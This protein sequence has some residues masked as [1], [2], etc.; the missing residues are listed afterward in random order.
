MAIL[1]AVGLEVAYRR[2]ISGSG[3]LHEPTQIVLVTRLTRVPDFRQVLRS[4]M[5]RVGRRQV[6]IERVVMRA[7]G[8]FRRAVDAVGGGGADRFAIDHG[9]RG[10]T[11]L[12]PSPRNAA[13]AEQRAD[14]LVGALQAHYVRAAAIIERGIRI[15]DHAASDDLIVRVVFAGGGIHA[16]GHAGDDVEGSNRGR[17]EVGSMIV[18]AHREILSV[19]PQAGYGV[20]IV[21]AHNDPGVQVLHVGKRWTAGSTG[22]FGELVHQAA[23][24]GLLFRHVVVILAASV[25]LA[26]I[27]AEGLD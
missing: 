17:A 27:K 10:E 22:E 1:R 26:G 12:E 24:K 16:T 5:V 20:A 3:G 14:V 18:V 2:Q 4:R 13:G 8:R 9:R 6:V 19:I 15:A 11:T 21:V 7:V 25:V 23:I